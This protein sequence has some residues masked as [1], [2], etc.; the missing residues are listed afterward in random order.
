VHNTLFDSV[1]SIIMLA[2]LFVDVER[3]RHLRRAIVEPAIRRAPIS[4]LY[5]IDIQ[6]TIT[7]LNS[8]QSIIMS[9][10][11]FVDVAATTLV[12]E[13]SLRARQQRRRLAVASPY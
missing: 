5:H 13:Q 8:V 2:K 3:C 6:V 10:K 9:A 12:D 4:E 1:L 7:M 11:C